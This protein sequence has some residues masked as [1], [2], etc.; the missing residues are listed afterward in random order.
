[1]KRATAKKRSHRHKRPRNSSFRLHCEPLED[2][3][4]LATFTPADAATLIADITTANGN[5]EADTV[6]LGGNTFTLTAVHSLQS[7]LP[8]IADDGAGHAL[9]IQNGTIERDAAAPAFRIIR[10]NP[11]GELILAN[12]TI[13]GGL[14]NNSGSGHGGGIY[15]RGTVTVSESTVA[16]NTASSS[17]NGFGGGIFNSGSLTVLNSTVSNNTASSSNGDF[18][19]ASGGAI[20]NTGTLTVIN[21]T[22]SGNKVRDGSGSSA[23]SDGGGIYN[24]GTLSVTNSTLAGNVV[25]S[26][27]TGT[28]RGGGIYNKGSSTLR[29]SIV[30][31]NIRISTT[32]SDLEGTAQSASANN[33]IGDPAT[34]GGIVNAMSG[35]IVG[36]GG[37]N[38]TISDVLLPL[39][40][41][42]G[43]TLTH[44]LAES[45][46]AIDAGSNSLALA[47][48]TSPLSTDQRG[49]G[50]DRIVNATVDIGAFAAQ[51]VVVVDTEP[52]SITA[53]PAVTIEADEDSSPANTGMATATDSADPTPTIA[54]SDVVTP[55]ASPQESTITRT[56]TATDA[57]GNQSSAVQ[58]IQIVDT[59]PP[60]IIAPADVTIEADEDASPAN[61]GTATGIDNADPNPTI[62]Y[63]DVV[64][65]GASPQEATITRTWTATDATGNQSS[66]EQTIQVVDTT[67][68]VVVAP[69]DVTLEAGDDTSPANTGTAT[70]TDNADPAPTLTFSD[71]VTPGASPQEYTI[72]RTWTATDATGNQGSAVQTIAVGD[73]TSPVV[74][75]PADVTVEA[76]DDTS[77]ANTGAATATDN[78]DPDPAVTFADVVTPGGSPHEYSIARTWTATDASGNQS[79]AVQA[80]EVVD[81]TSP[82]IVAPADLVVGAE[83][84]T[85]PAHTGTATATDNADSNPAITY[86]DVVTPGAS[87]QEYRITRTWTATDAA[88]N[89]SSAEQTIQ[90][91]DTT[92]PALMVPAD[93]TL[94]FG[95]DTSPANTGMATAVDNADPLPTISFSDVRVNGPS[96]QEYTLT[97]AWTA[98]DATGNM[99][100]ANQIITVVPDTT[101]PVLTVPANVTI[102]STDDSSPAGT[103]TASA[104]DKAD[105]APA[106]TFADAV[107]PGGSPI[108]R[109]WTA[110]DLSGN[111]STG[112][113]VITIDDTVP[114]AEVYIDSSGNLVV[115][116][117]AS[118]SDEI[119]VARGHAGRLNVRLNNTNFDVTPTGNQIIIR[120][121]DGDNKIVIAGN[122]DDY[123]TVITTTGNGRNYV[124]GGGGADTVTT[125]DGEDTILTGAGD[126]V[127]D[128]GGGIDN[129]DAGS[130]SDNVNA[131]A[132]A[133]H[134]AGGAGDDV[135]RGGDGNDVMSGGD[136]DDIVLG[137]AGN[138]ILSGG[139]GDD[140]VAGGAGSDTLFGR[141]GNDI[142][143]GG[144]DGDG[145]HGNAGDDL[146]ISG[147]T[148]DDDDPAQLRLALQ[149]WG[150]N[151]LSIPSPFAS[152]GTDGAVDG[153]NGDSGGDFHVVEAGDRNFRLTG[154]DN[155]QIIT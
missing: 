52:P 50:F 100:T 49:T 137:G 33:L 4:L 37:A 30:A 106:I 141:M 53:P 83:D 57:T 136:G 124:D 1:M 132:G 29:N 116:P 5:G 145:L 14:A 148:E 32:P 139:S 103:G 76:G 75:A 127:I 58:T 70:A 110:T 24:A 12:S 92:S 153:V 43:P 87:P 133:D 90:V 142:L 99:S 11:G 122:L 125:G 35:N 46:P 8:V 130:G 107:A 89:S 27:A 2:R 60:A 109:T 123:D 54:F 34:S 96:P 126:D 120:A 84:D 47:P 154:D 78:A 121:G 61:T 64:S 28:N 40:D 149:E 22:L 146:L 86:S 20:G 17:G 134:V 138:D 16:G 45:S 131:G 95:E 108:T 73:T 31:G 150:A 112:V 118:G 3:R 21:S 101:P 13:S 82:V 88:G 135:L 93:V 128:S 56:W 143:Q 77:P 19:S 115:E 114:E 91:V 42:G 25:S 85:S 9:T 36:D 38:V 65:P 98:S 26:G 147:T 111:S 55:G 74:V 18:V 97:R 15:N 59:T 41:N 23:T 94:E 105:P 72:T 10:V 144:A 66:A 113:Q 67:S 69:A 81:T 102:R 48:D 140:V 104:T 129:I 79:S 62:T 71:V 51:A 155:L 117:T 68:P 80:I 151:S 7:G 63:S 152:L 6:D 44:A 119:I 39:A